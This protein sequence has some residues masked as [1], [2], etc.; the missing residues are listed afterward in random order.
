MT[1][2][3]VGGVKISLEGGGGH[4]RERW[5]GAAARANQKDGTGSVSVRE[6]RKRESRSSLTVLMKSRAGRE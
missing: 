2:D 6:K 5:G 3:I 1:P 4:F